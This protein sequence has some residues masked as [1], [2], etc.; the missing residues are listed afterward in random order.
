MKPWIFICRQKIN[1]IL[2]VFHLRYCKDIA[3]PLFWVLS[4]CLA[5]QT[6][7]KEILSTCQKLLFICRQ[8]KS[9]P[10]VFLDILQ[11]YANF[12]FW[13]L[14]ACLAMHTQNDSINLQKISV[15]ICIT[16]IQFIIHFFLQALHL[17]ESCNLIDHPHFGQ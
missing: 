17:K 1:F 12:L 10:H 16:K 6:Q 8:K 5:Q 4:A 2:H 9:N 7:I 11:R 15:L 13:V 14:W 3:K